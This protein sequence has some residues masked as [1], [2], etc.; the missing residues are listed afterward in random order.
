MDRGE[1]GGTIEAGARGANLLLRRRHQHQRVRP[2]GPRVARQRRDPS[3]APALLVGRG[4]LRG[5]RAA[6]QAH[7]HPRQLLHEP[8]A[9]ERVGRHRSTRRVLQP[10]WGVQEQLRVLQRHG[11]GGGGGVGAGRREARGQVLRRHW[12]AVHLH[13]GGR[14]YPHTRAGHPPGAGGGARCG[15]QDGDLR[16]AGPGGVRGGFRRNAGRV[17]RIPTK[18]LLHA[19][20]ARL[21]QHHRQEALNVLRVPHHPGCRGGHR[22][23][24][25][26]LGA[27]G[28]LHQGGG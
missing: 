1:P 15:G 26:V 18:R 2:G 17:F 9:E 22:A 12:I 19:V 4:V 3:H 24:G 5:R 23:S 8:P 13:G 6:A 27:G 21:L 20:F 25:A 10:T 7:V 14:R 28:H 11:R 16:G